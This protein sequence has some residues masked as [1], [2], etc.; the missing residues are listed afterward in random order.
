MQTVSLNSDEYIILGRVSGTASVSAPKKA[1]ERERKSL[2]TARQPEFVTVL[3]GDTGNYGFI[4]ESLKET[5]SST[6]KAVALATYD[7]LDTAR[8]NKADALLC[9]TR[10]VAVESSGTK[11]IITATVSGVAVRLKTPATVLKA[12]PKGDDEDY[13][14]DAAEED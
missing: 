6:E 11:S 1:F 3:R 10:E 5:M 14:T 13:T 4:G 12:P 7:M 8:Y 9:V 2:A